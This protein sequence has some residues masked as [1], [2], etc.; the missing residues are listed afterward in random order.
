MEQAMVQRLR[1]VLGD[2]PPEDVHAIIAFALF[3]SE[4]RQAER[5]TAS[6]DK[7]TE[8]E[9]TKILRVL[10][11]VAA[12]SAEAETG[13]PVSNRDHDRYLYGTD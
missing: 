7:L 5:E 12:L 6:K 3:V 2:L 1:E 8:A 10:E 13:P 4:R 11:A 9:H